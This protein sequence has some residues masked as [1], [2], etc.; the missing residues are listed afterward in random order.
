MNNQGK[1]RL[2]WTDVFWSLSIFI[3]L[4]VIFVVALVESGGYRDL[5]EKARMNSANG[6]GN[7][8]LS[9]NSLPPQT[10]TSIYFG[11]LFIWICIYS[12]FHSAGK[13]YCN[14]FFYSFLAM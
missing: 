7:G 6:N 13:L 5:L 10:L 1:S 12:G 9:L 11:Q 2:L 14:K 3:G 8:D 4:V